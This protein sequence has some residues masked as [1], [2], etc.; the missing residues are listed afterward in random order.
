[1]HVR[2]CI[3]DFSKYLKKDWLAHQ[4]HIPRQKCGMYMLATTDEEFNILMDIEVKAKVNGDDIRILNQN[5]LKIL[6]PELNVENVLAA[7]YSPEE[8]LVDPFLMV[9]SNLYVALHYGCQ[10]KTRC[11]VVNL[12]I[13]EEKSGIWKIFVEERSQN[14]GKLFKKFYLAKKVINCGGNYS[15]E[16]DRLVPRNSNQNML[17]PAF[18]IKPGCLHFIYIIF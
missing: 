7:L 17:H 16:L 4:I 13:D 5:E 3:L 9:L 12:K 1:M 15:D 11:R 6:E 18:V 10:L 2:N 14:G 8:F